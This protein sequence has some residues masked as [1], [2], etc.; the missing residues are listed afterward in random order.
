MLHEAETLSVEELRQAT[1]DLAAPALLRHLVREAFPGRT[2]VTSSLRARSIVVL[3]MVAEIDR[4]LPVIFCHSPYVYP[5]S[6]E[7]RAQIVR[8]LG[9]TD[10][11]DP[12][13]DESGVVAE[14]KDHHEDIQSEIWGGGMIETEVH[15]NRSLADFDC[16]ISAAYHTPYTSAPTPR[17]IQDGRMLRVYPLSGWTREDVH[18]YLSDHDL[19]LHPLVSPPSYHY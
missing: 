19:P 10:V 1:A 13:P 8:R 9:L 18:G 6:V 12:V 14:D 17:L 16:W 2:V 3:H 11:R 4:S 7:Y 15:L 5:E